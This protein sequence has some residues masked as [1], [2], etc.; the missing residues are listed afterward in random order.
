MQNNLYLFK[1][2]AAIF[3]NKQT[4]NPVKKP[5]SAKTE[6]HGFAQVY[7]SAEPNPQKSDR[8]LNR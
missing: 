7:T 6:N 3:P 2:P 8:S 4:K 1:T 5:F